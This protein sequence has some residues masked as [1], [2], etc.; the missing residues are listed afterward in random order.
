MS[1]KLCKF[2]ASFRKSAVAVAEALNL[3]FFS[4]ETQV[5]HGT[6]MFYDPETDVRYAMY[7]TGYVRRFIKRSFYFNLYDS[8]MWNGYQ[9][10]P[11]FINKNQH[12]HKSTV[13]IPV[14]NPN[15]QL[16]IMVKA[17]INYRNNH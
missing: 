6:L 5:N 4:S 13:R 3:V 9:L 14:L 15:E 11:T 2:N 1:I 17:V 8:S 7:E 16:G 12:G 10:N